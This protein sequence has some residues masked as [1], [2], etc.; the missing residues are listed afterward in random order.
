MPLAKGTT[1]SGPAVRSDFH[2]PIQAP[3]G[4]VIRSWNVTAHSEAD[5]GSISYRLLAPWSRK[6][7]DPA[8]NPEAGAR[9]AWAQLAQIGPG[10]WQ[11]EQ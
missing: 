4:T 6:Y 3:T 8:D 10:H 7:G 9:E 5:P 2:R 11:P 1:L